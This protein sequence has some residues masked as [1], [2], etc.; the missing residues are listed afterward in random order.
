MSICKT[1]R[2]DFEMSLYLPKKNVSLLLS[3]T[4]LWCSFMVPVYSNQDTKNILDD[5][6]VFMSE[7]EDIEV[8]QLYHELEKLRDHD[9]MRA[10]LWLNAEKENKA[11]FKKNSIFISLGMN[12]GPAINFEK[13]KITEAFFP[14]DWAISEFSSIYKALKSDFKDF[15]KLENLVVTPRALPLVNHGVFDK[16]YRINFIHDFKNDST[17]LYDYEQVRD[18]YY[19][20]I[21]RFYRAL[22]LG[23]HI[24]FFRT[25][26]KKQEAIKLNNLIQKKF[27]KIKYTLVVMN[28]TPE[29]KRAW[30][31]KNVKHFFIKDVHQ[32]VAQHTRGKNGWDNVFKKLKVT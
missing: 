28:D 29:F 4:L 24:Y 14:F 9:A 31:I 1:E 5:S 32:A 26:I 20:R 22:K 27:P 8:G 19:R 7:R 25:K 23:K 21:D 6:A 15:L 17:P 30:N 12:C 3:T 13:N 18:K 10:P 11:E 16:G 2:K